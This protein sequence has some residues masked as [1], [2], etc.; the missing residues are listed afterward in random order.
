MKLR[1][2][3]ALALTALLLVSPAAAI[4]QSTPL[5]DKRV[6]VTPSSTD[7][8]IDPGATVASKFEIINSTDVN[9]AVEVS[10][11]PYHVEGLDYD[12]RFSQLPGTTNAADWIRFDGPVRQTLAGARTLAYDYTVSVP[13]SAKPGGYYVVLFATAVPTEKA[14]NGLQSTSRL[15]NILYLT[16]NGP[17]TNAGTAEAAPMPLITLQ[18][19]LEPGVIVRNTGGLHYKSRVGMSVR[20]LFGREVY[21]SETERLVLPQTS[22]QIA[23]VWDRLPP[24]GIYKVSLTA[25]AAGQAQAVPDR[26]VV[27]IRPWVLILGLVFVAAVTAFYLT[28]RKRSH[29]K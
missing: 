18:D 22:R 19:R 5:R 7:L 28:N 26:W 27:A 1:G 20:D 14:E 6:A 24:I 11:S 8:A 21:R 12:P 10:A 25:T 16:V 3:T 13:A 17:V 9:Y 23:G 4:A 2:M 29:K 15:G